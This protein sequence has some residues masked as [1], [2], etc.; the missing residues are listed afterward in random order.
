MV[1]YKTDIVTEFLHA[2]F[3]KMKKRCFRIYDFIKHE[4]LLK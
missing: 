3:K 1:A 2:Y 4:M